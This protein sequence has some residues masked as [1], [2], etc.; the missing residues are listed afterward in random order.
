VRAINDNRVYANG[1]AL[2]F[3]PGSSLE[4]EDEA[5]YRA[6][7]STDI[8]GTVTIGAGADATIQ[9][10][11]NFF[12]TFQ[13]GSA[14]TMNGDL[15]LINNNINIKDLATFSGTGALI[16]P[17]GSHLVVD[18]QADVGVLLDMH[19]AFRPGN[20]NGIGRVNLSDFQQAGTAELF[21]ELIGTGLAQYDRL[22]ITGDAVISG[23]LNIDIDEV[24]PG[25][26]F[27]PGLGNTF[28]IISTTG[29]RSG[30]FGFVDIAGMPDGL[31]FRVNYLPNGVQLEVVNKPIYSADFDED[32]DVDPTDF[33]I[34][35]G[36][37]DLNQLGDA[38][39]DNDTDGFDFLVWQQQF[40]S[41]PTAA[42]VAD[43]VPEPGAGSLLATALVAAAAGSQRRRP[44]LA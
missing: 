32:G 24:S 42:P 9:V 6:S 23:Y 25:V 10:A 13:A 35:K 15:T 20:F 34:W 5:T 7:S 14:T 29:I 19:G 21:V 4:L 26:P 12:L 17:D 3:N 2:D 36:A 38:D 22:A 28:N 44:P 30:T 41:K 31:T 27:V 8:G 43:V 39:G 37:F 33:A 40:G 11:N 18:N 16:I 1:F